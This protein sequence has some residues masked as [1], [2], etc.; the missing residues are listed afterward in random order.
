MYFLNK[1]DI[2]FEVSLFDGSLGN[3]ARSL[4]QECITNN[5][6]TTLFRNLETTVP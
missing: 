2:E 5:K 1:F 4:Y 6:H 3:S